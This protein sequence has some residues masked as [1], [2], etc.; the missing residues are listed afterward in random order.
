MSGPDDEDV[1][2]QQWPLDVSTSEEATEARRVARAAANARQQATAAEKAKLDAVAAQ[3]QLEVPARTRKQ[4]SEDAQKKIRR[5]LEREKNVSESQ[6]N[7]RAITALRMRRNGA[8]N[9]RI[10]KA[11]GYKSPSSVATLIG[12]ALRD[13]TYDPHEVEVYRDY[14]LAELMQQGEIAV[15]TVRNPGYLYDVKGE[16]VMGPDG[17]FLENI[18]ERTK[19]QTEWRHI[20]ESARKLLGIDAPQKKIRKNTIIIKNIRE[21]AEQL[22]IVVDDETG[23]S[24]DIVDAQVIEQLSQGANDSQ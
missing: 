9:K 20:Q 8:D 6:R 21:A 5:D 3:A 10:A 14:F 16:L 1:W 2:G 15:E 24:L 22:G 23:G 4:L 13:H 11:L 12:D 17:Q 7:L 18:S 19:A